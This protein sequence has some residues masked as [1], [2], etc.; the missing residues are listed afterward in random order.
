MT[1]V[2]KSLSIPGLET[3]FDSLAVAIDQ[4]GPEKSQLFLAKLALLNANALAD[5]NLFQEHIRAALQDL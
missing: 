5:E 1:T 4:A 2:V 3:V